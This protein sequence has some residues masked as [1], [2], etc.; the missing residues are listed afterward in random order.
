MNQSQREE[1]IRR[2]R[3]GRSFPL[4]GHE[5]YFRL[6]NVNTN[7]SITER[8]AKRMSSRTPWPC[9]SR[10]T[11]GKDGDGWHNMLVFGDNLQAMKDTRAG[12]IE[13][14]VLTEG[15]S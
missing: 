3:Q 4:N 12:A 13:L 15:D 2:L 9:P 6:R 10:R 11:F 14:P 7:W 8:N 1:V 5:S